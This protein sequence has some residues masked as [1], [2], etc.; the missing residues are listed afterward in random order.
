MK[1]TCFVITALVFCAADTWGFSPT[2]T[3][4][5]SSSSSRCRRRFPIDHYATSERLRWGHCRS[6]ATSYDWKGFK[7]KSPLALS[8]YL[9]SSCCSCRRRRSSSISSSIRSRCCSLWLHALPS[10]DVHNQDERSGNAYD[11]SI[12]DTLPRLYVGRTSSKVV[13]LVLERTMAS[14]NSLQEQLESQVAM[15][16]R[17]LDDNPAAMATMSTVL[18]E[19]DSVISLSMEQT[20]YLLKVMRIFSKQK[21][22]DDILVRVFDGL[23]GEWLCRVITPNESSSSDAVPVAVAVAKG[24]NTKGSWKPNKNRPKE[25]L[26]VQCIKQLIQQQKEQTANE[27]WLLFAPIKSKRM[28]LIIEKCT[29]LGVGLFCPILTDFTDSTAASSYFSMV[30]GMMVGGSKE[31]WYGSDDEVSVSDDSILFHGGNVDIRKKSGGES[32]ERLP[33]VACEAAEQCERLTVPQFVNLV[34]NETQGIVT[35]QTLLQNWIHPA[36]GHTRY[37]GRMILVCRERTQ[38]RGNH[39]HSILDAMEQ[40]SKLNKNIAYLVGPEGGWSPKE[41]ALFD[42]YCE[43]YPESIMGVTLGTNILRAETASILAVGAFSLWSS[44][45]K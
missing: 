31:D 22:K 36:E 1:N 20:F 40:A 43:D 37:G 24:K 17:V 26:R 11:S 9:S 38:E 12:H 10:S 8:P 16:H 42:Q 6:F 3:M 15:N 29:E 45:S 14:P 28:K 5:H 4:P 21:C 34:E 25:P 18:L 23:H 19:V 27:P 7:I 30:G 13:T 35:I 33:S 41:E 39:V 44:Q 2:S 32:S